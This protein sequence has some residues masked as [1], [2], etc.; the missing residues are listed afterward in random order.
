VDP[1]RRLVRSPD[2]R[3]LDVLTGGADAA[4]AFLAIVD[5]RIDSA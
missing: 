5:E 3:D 1:Q 4:D 2:G